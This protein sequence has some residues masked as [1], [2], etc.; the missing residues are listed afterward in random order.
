MKWLIKFLAT[1]FYTG[2]TPIAPGT[3]GSLIGVIIYLGM[4]RLFWP[5]YLLILVVLSL[6]GICISNKATVY[7]FKEKDSKRI[8]IDEIIGFL[9][10]MFFIIPAEISSSD[11]LLFRYSKF[12]IV[13]F[14]V[15]RVIDILKPYPL[16]RLEKLPGGWGVM[17]DDLLAGVY[18][19]LIMQV[20]RQFV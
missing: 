11:I 16:R 7:F 20:I 2:Y 12:I 3:A 10:T 13:G 6:F 8:V 17:C 1:G 19:N 5:H 9:I 15:F 4:Y 18:A 14:L